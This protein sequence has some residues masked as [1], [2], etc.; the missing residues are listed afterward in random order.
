MTNEE[1]QQKHADY[2]ANIDSWLLYRAAY[3]GTK[4]MLDYGVVKQLT[5]ENSTDYA[6][7][8]K[9]IFGFNLSERLIG[10]IISYLFAK[11]TNSDYSALI[12]NKLFQMFRSN[13]NKQGDQ[14][15]TYMQE[16]VLL[17]K[18]YG[19][20]GI[21]INKPMIEGIRT[22]DT[23]VTDNVYPYLTCYT[24]LSIYDWEYD[25]VNGERVLSYLKLLDEKE[26]FNLWWP[27]RWEIW[28]KNEKGEYFPS[29]SGENELGVIPFVVLRNGNLSGAML[30]TSDIKEI[31]RHDATLIN[32]AHSANEIIHY[33]GFPML[34]VPSKSANDKSDIKVDPRAV[35]EYDGRFPGAKAE[36]LATAVAAPIKAIIDWNQTI[37]FEAYKSIS[38]SFMNDNGGGVESGEAKKRAFQ[39]FNAALAKSAT[40][41]ETAERNI[42]KFWLMW[43]DDLPMF[44][45]ISISRPKDFDVQNLADDIDMLTVATNM[46]QSGEY[47][48]QVQKNIVVKTLPDLSEEK[49]QIIN[50]EIESGGV[51]F[52]ESGVDNAD[53]ELNN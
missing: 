18:I 44:E 38:A 36:W 21:F 13:A 25:L 3:E 29:E 16:Q 10:I 48:K 42:I 28:A 41:M 37:V 53:D 19:H 31:A 27:D 12:D 9:T 50:T 47:S 35:I 46:V 52:D 2:K 33:N 11:P 51:V 40:A 17:S 7:R 24:P 6:A 14:F 30:G 22:V 43:Q 26:R 20:V 32:T 8:L 15:E 39:S 23:D 34:Q 5:G 49:S 45:Q 1:L 4:A